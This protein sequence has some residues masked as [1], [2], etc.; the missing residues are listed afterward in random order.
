MAFE[1]GITWKIKNVDLYLAFLVL[2]NNNA[3]DSADEHRYEMLKEVASVT[4]DIT[5]GK[6]K[7]VKGKVKEESGK[8]TGNKSQEI[9]GKAEHAAGKVQEQYGKAKRNIKKL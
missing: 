9:R 4:N 2:G 5:K 3:P 8:L 1:K 6:V 7:Q